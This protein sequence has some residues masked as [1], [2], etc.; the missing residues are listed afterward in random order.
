MKQALTSTGLVLTL[1]A[2]VSLAQQP[3]DLMWSYESGNLIAGSPAVG[4]DGTIFFV[5][6]SLVAVTNMGSNR[7][8]F[9]LDSGP[10]G[11]PTVATD[12][13]IYVSRVSLYSVNPDGSEKWLYPANGKGSTPSLGRDGT[14]YVHGAYL[15]ALSGMGTLTWSNAIGGSI[16]FGSPSVGA[17]QTIY[18]PAPDSQSLYAIRPDGTTK[19]QAGLGATTADTAAIGADGT[20]YVSGLGLYALSAAGSNLWV[21]S[22]NSFFG[23]CPAIGE[24][25]T[26][27]VASFGAGSLY[28]LSRAGAV[29]WKVVFASEDPTNAP[30][31]R[32]PAIDSKGTIYVAAFHS[33]YAISPQGTV[34]WTFTHPGDTSNPA[35]RSLTSPAIGPD[36]TVYATFGSKLYAIYNTNK[37][38]DSAW[39][40]YRQNPRHTGKVEKP[41]LQQPKKRADANFQFQLYA[42]I[43]QTQA[44]QSSTD[45]ITWAPLTNVVVTNVPMDVVDLS[46]SNFPARFYRTHSQ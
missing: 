42:Q 14:V 24:D 40:M 41:M 36:G 13:A 46:A 21:N 16:F 9:P 31:I 8:T 22:S 4:L 45:L 38:A 12:G 35:N 11:S 17:D 30:P 32:C 33:V 10:Y 7:W 23:S 19:W 2:W 43:D 27:Y 25:G 15:E 39:P 20:V 6:G 5:N 29:R 1:T 28:A 37:L 26:I 3:G 18:A 34:Q 44:V